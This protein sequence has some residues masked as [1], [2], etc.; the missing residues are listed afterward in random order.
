MS[1]AKNVGETG[2]SEESAIRVILRRLRAVCERISDVPLHR[3]GEL[4]NIFEIFLINFTPVAERPHD[5]D[6]I[7]VLRRVLTAV[8]TSWIKRRSRAN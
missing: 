2:T 4:E 8:P 3:R 7:L 6:S 5:A 1:G